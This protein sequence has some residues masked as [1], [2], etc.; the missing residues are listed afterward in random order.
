MVALFV[1]L[2]FAA[3]ILIDIVV[4]KVSYARARQTAGA[5]ELKSGLALAPAFAGLDVNHFKM[6]KGLFY[7]N[8]HTWAKID[9]DGH[10]KL[11]IDDFLQKVVGKI[12]RIELLNPGES[13]K[14]GDKLIKIVQN[15]RA[16]YLKSPVD[17]RVV[18]VNRGLEADPSKI[19]VD[20]YKSW[21]VELEPENL[22]KSIHSMKIAD[23]AARWFGRELKRFKEF[24]NV[25]MNPNSLVGQT[26]QDG[27]IPVDGLLERM[28]DRSWKKFE[29]EFLAQ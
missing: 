26:A 1:V 14:A 23:S 4:Q 13:V 24:V 15:G 27:G 2:T 20:P 19:K 10:V 25:E 22:S 8:N 29:N 7:S 6:E 16:M 3:L 21:A 9:E 28:E 11:G 17:G 5:Y 12:D 18:M